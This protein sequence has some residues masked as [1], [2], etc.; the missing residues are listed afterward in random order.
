MKMVLELE[1][2]RG[3]IKTMLSVV[4]GDCMDHN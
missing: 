3:W 1:K 2:T 4:N